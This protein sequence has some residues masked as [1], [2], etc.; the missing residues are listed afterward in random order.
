METIELGKCTY[1][2]NFLFLGFFL[3]N[4]LIVISLTPEIEI[5]FTFEPP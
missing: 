2:L 3:N 4:L 5:T 1:L